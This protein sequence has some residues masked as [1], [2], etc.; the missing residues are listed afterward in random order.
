MPLFT[1]VM[2]SVLMTLQLL[3]LTLPVPEQAHIC[4]QSDPYAE[5]AVLGCT[6]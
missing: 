3:P 1:G 2:H 5:H 4:T 6:G